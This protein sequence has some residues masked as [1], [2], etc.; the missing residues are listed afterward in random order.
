M[1]IPVVITLLMRN[2]CIAHPC[3]IPVVIILLPRNYCIAHPCHSRGNYL[4]IAELLHCPSL[5]HSRDNDIKTD[6]SRM[7]YHVP[8]SVGALLLEASELA[9]VVNGDE[10]FPD[11]Q[12]N[13]TDEN[14]ARDH[15]QYHRQHVH[16]LG[17]ACNPDTHAHM[18]NWL[19][20]THARTHARV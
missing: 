1:P 10:Q 14:D 6:K 4:V 7:T 2:Y 17:T 9:A 18:H 8:A 20:Y 16:R 13:E 15:A 11:Q 5:C 3:V 12:Q 19:C